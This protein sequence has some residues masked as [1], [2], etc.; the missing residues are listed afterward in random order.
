MGKRFELFY[1]IAEVV[2]EWKIKIVTN[3][4]FLFLKKID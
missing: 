3:L 1:W 4:L 2:I